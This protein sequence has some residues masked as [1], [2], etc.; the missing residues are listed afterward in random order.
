MHDASLGGS[1]ALGIVTRFDLIA[2]PVST[3]WAG[4]VIYNITHLPELLEVYSDYLQDEPDPKTHF[5]FSIVPSPTGDFAALTFYHSGPLN[6]PP[7]DFEPFF[8]IPSIEN[9]VANTNI[10][11]FAF[12]LG[13][14]DNPTV[15]ALFRAVSYKPTLEMNTAAAEIFDSATRSLRN[16]DGFFT[17]NAFQPISKGVQTPRNGGNILG[18][19]PENGM[20]QWN[21]L[22][23]RWNNSRDDE[24]VHQAMANATSLI[25]AKAKG[26]GLDVDFIYLND[27]GADQPIYKSYGH[28]NFVKLQ[29]LQKA[30]FNNFRLFNQLLNRHFAL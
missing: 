28:A 21:A 10:S 7:S 18:L 8:N 13:L 19:S 11:D 27:A 1:S 22:T 24:R 25:S 23:F 6:G 2:H 16:I 20:I 5:I 9:T 15:R 26:L 14:T 29:T 12:Q 3:V 30:K 4:Q 17:I